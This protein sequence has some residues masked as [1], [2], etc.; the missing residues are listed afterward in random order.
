MQKQTILSG[1]GRGQQIPQRRQA[2]GSPWLLQSPSRYCLCFTVAIF[3]MAKKLFFL[4]FDNALIKWC[5]KQQTW[6]SMVKKLSGN[7]DYFYIWSQIVVVFTTL[8]LAIKR[9]TK[10]M[11]GNLLINHL[12]LW[13]HVVFQLLILCIVMCLSQVK[14][15][16]NG[17]VLI[18]R[19]WSKH[20]LLLSLIWKYCFDFL[21]HYNSL[22]IFSFPIF[23][24][25]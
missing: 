8:R 19:E 14:T 25:F 11:C 12:W 13:R 6:G 10:Y 23:N 22:P 7:G 24:C 15:G 3:S 4:L 21:K 20:L 16:A 5:C 1:H 17:W 2:P 9:A 18:L